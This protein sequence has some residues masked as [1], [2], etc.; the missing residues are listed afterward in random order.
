MVEVTVSHILCQLLNGLV[1]GMLLALI[2]MGLSLIFGLL[3]IA[4]FAHGVFY[5]LG[6]YVGY[7]V[8]VLGGNYWIALP[9]VGIVVAA[10]GLVVEPLN[11]RFYGEDPA[12]RGLFTL[13]FAFALSLALEES[14]RWTWGALGKKF[15]PPA[16]LD[17][18]IDLG[19]FI[20]PAY[21]LFVILLGAILTIAVWLFLKK[22]QVGLIIRAGLQNREMVQVLGI[23]ISKVY[24]LT[25][26]LGVGI[27]GVAGL[28]A[29]PLVG[30][31]PAMGVEIQVPSFVVVVVGGMGSFLGSV[32]SGIIIGEV[33]TLPVIWEP[34]VS[35]V[36]IYVFMAIML[37]AKPGGLFGELER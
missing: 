30:V 24:T 3:D 32:V 26:I 20:Y 25:Y 16:L 10:L 27:A 29:A 11:R 9:V 31:Y 22:T 18:V 4:N 12:K 8:I 17:F 5:A 37:I 34:R 7:Q 1:L 28:A 21:R 14:I 15:S 33:A 2:A 13:I 23:D 6:A 19:L 35:Q 36:A